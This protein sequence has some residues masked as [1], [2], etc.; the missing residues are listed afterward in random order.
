MSRYITRQDQ[1]VAALGDAEVQALVVSDLTNVRYLCGYVGS[2]GT[3]VV[4]PSRRVLLT[5]FRYLQSAAAQTKGVEIV[6]AGRD[7]ALKL[8]AVIGEI[9][10]TRVGFES[11]HVSHARHARMVA[12]LPGVEL[13]PTS[14]IVESVRIRKDADEIDVIARAS[15]WHSRRASTACFVDAPSARW[16]GSS[17]QSCAQPVPTARASTSSWRPGSAAPCRTPFRPMCQFPPTRW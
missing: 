3:L 14:G 6:E 10:A 17:A 5:D 1:V 11:A 7:L 13:V 8:A 16:H 2:N 4:S 12:D 9:A 15:T